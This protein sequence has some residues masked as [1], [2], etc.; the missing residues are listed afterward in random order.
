MLEVISIIAISWWIT[1]FEP[2]TDLLVKK[3]DKLNKYVIK[4]LSCWKCNSFWIA[5]VYAIITQQ[6]YTLPFICS[7]IA[8]I[9]DSSIN[10]F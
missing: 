9:I 3:A 10:K 7:M 2:L 4:L 1:H 6:F 8:Y 5:M